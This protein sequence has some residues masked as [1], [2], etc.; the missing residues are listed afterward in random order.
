MAIESEV[1]VV[2]GGLAGLMAGIAGRRAGASV[3]IVSASESTLRQA[4]GL[5]DVLGYP[6][7]D[8]GPARDPLERVD[9]LPSDHPYRIVGRAAIEAGL[10]CFDAVVGEA[11]RGGTSNALL[12]TALGTIK[13]TARYPRTMSAGRVSEPADTLLVGFE[14]L[15]AMDANVAAD[16]LLAAEVPFAV[17][18]A[19]I[20]FPGGSRTDAALTRYAKALDRDESINGTACR[21][22]LAARIRPH[23][24]DV[25]RVGLPAM[26]G[27]ERAATVQEDLGNRL[28]VRVFEVPTG[29]P[30]IPGMRLAARLETAFTDAGGHFHGG[31]PVV[32]AEVEDG[33]IERIVVD[34]NDAMIPYT[35]TEYVLATGGLVGKGITASREAVTEPVFGC[36][37]P[38]PGDRSEWYADGVFDAHPYPRF[39]VRI[40]EEL[41]P[42]DADGDIQ[43]ENLRAGGAVIGGADFAAEKS[44]SGISIATGVKAGTAA[45]RGVSG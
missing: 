8:A 38:H 7:P 25:D 45:A 26:L 4:S 42:L 1:V 9:E 33:R 13:P 18:A 32:D 35:G 24:G 43:I 21:E 12:P 11:Y 3:T 41:H 31:V 19:T 44:G 15:P 20:P 39:G 36:H 10:T 22:E 28:G 5:I 16:R 29:P 17:S 27:I 30:S 40:D 2:G 37:V 34:R 6:S 14:R 23:L